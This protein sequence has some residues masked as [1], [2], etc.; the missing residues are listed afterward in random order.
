VLGE[1]VAAFEREFA[2]ATGAPH[3]VGVASGYDA[4]TLALRALGLRR[5]EVILPANTFTGTAL[6][7]VRAG[8]VPVL[9]E[10]DPD[11]LQLDPGRAARRIGPRTVAI[12]PVHLYGQVCDL[13]A[14]ADLARRRGLLLVEDCAQAHGALFE[15]RPVGTFGDAAAFSF[16]PTKSLGGL[17]DGG[18]VATGDAAVAE[19]VRTLR[20]YGF[21]APGRA[22][23]VGLNSRLDELQAAFLRVKLP[24]LGEI[25]R[26]R[27]GIAARYDRE[28]DPAF[29]RPRAAAGA[30]PARSVYPVLHPRRDALAAHLAARGI[31]TGVHYPVPP[32]RQEALRWILRGRFPLTERLHRTTLSLPL[33]FGMTEAEVDEVI[34]AA[35]GFA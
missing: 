31:G 19:R 12:L 35:N 28:L 1:Q 17:G 2:S 8:L 4:I 24:R 5:G 14:V 11:T 23:E 26:R 34:A 15:G 16:Y 33:S 6:A 10:P 20:N 9:A 7:V 32:H 22:A 13:R 25:V 3:A 30:A 21:D 27:N 29:A 18:A